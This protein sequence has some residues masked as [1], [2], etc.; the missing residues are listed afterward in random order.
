M[1]ITSK[2]LEQAFTNALK[3]AGLATKKDLGKT[4]ENIAS[5]LNVAFQEHEDKVFG[6]FDGMDKKLDRMERIIS[7]WPAPSSI[8]NLMDRVSV[9]EKHLKLKSRKKVKIS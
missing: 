6:R 2:Q 4:E 1:D 7:S 8:T 5:T 3:K 9:I